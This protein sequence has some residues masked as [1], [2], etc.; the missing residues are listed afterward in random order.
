M[1]FGVL[2]NTSPGGAMSAPVL[3]IP[4]PL[5][6]VLALILTDVVSVTLNVL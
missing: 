6:A 4:P 2:L 5:V 1:L 3:K